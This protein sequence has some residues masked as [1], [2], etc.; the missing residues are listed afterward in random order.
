[1]TS[2]I[3]AHLNMLTLKTQI[4]S[5]MRAVITEM[6]P[7]HVILALLC[8]L[9]WKKKIF[10]STIVLAK[11]FLGYMKYL[12]KDSNCVLLNIRICTYLRI[13]ATLSRSITICAHVVAKVIRDRQWAHLLHSCNTPSLSTL[14]NNQQWGPP[15]LHCGTPSLSCNRHNKALFCIK[16]ACWQ[17]KRLID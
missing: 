5:N 4:C 13:T 16:L 1:M 7:L 12:G 11:L 10:N 8:L 3:L 15:A 9:F 14:L 2:S 6:T 17:G